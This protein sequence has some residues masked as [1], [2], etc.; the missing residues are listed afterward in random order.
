MQD[1]RLNLVLA[2][3]LAVLVLGVHLADGSIWRTG[4]AAARQRRWVWV[5]VVF[6]LWLLGGFG[7]LRA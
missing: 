5:T 6:L 2:V 7:A 3:L 1:P 4:P